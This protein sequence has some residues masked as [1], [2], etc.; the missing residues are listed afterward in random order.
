MQFVKSILFVIEPDSQTAFARAVHEAKVNGAAITMIDAQRDMERT[1]PS[2]KAAMLRHREQRA[3]HLVN[4]I[5]TE[6]VP[7]EIKI[8]NGTP[9]IEVI[10]EAISGKHDLIVKAAEARDGGGKW[11]FGST[12]WHLMRKCPCPVWIVKVAKPRKLSRIL[13]AVDPDPDNETGEAL[14]AAILRIATRIAKQEKSEL[15]VVHAW[16]VPGED[17][18]RSG[19][20]GL[21]REEVDQFVESTKE[22]HRVWLKSLLHKQE[23]DMAETT[24]HFSRGDPGVVIP[25]IAEEC[26]ADLVVMGTVARTGVPGFFIGNTAEKT[27]GRIECSVVTVKPE[28]FESPIQA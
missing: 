15:H 9:F 13:A 25:R 2:L 6:G 20:V 7:I 26:S 11:L 8:V 17:L 1:L 19:R 12:D 16:T 27:L 3:D 18:M 10:K 28:G 24:V 22:D 23:L 21:P 5:D 14:N 4:S